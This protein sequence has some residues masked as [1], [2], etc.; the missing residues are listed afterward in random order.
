MGCRAPRELTSRARGVQEGGLPKE[1]PFVLTRSRANQLTGESHD[2][3]T[4][5]AY[6]PCVRHAVS[7]VVVSLFA[8]VFLH[9][10][11]AIRL[12]NPAFS[13]YLQ[14]GLPGGP[15]VLLTVRG[16]SSGRS[17]RAPVAMME[18]GDR[19]FVQ[20]AFGEVNWVR[21]LRAS[22]RAVVTKGR[23]SDVVDAVELAPEI[24]GAIL[25]ESLAPYARSRLLRAVVGPTIR[26]PIGVLHYFGVRVDEAVNEYVADARRYPVFELLPRRAADQPADALA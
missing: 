4:A 20:A 16:R 19:R 8:F 21:N 23:H 26:P 2:G 11:W 12:L 3:G 24:A 22:G 6:D 18:F 7:A 14:V 5:R 1:S 13:R 17:R 15:N 10:G 9:G 25:R